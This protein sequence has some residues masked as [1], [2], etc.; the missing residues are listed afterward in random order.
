MTHRSEPR[1]GCPHCKGVGVVVV[2]HDPDLV[3]ECPCTQPEELRYRL[4]WRDDAT[5]FVAVFAG[6][7]ADVWETATLSRSETEHIRR[8]MPNGEQTDILL[9]NEA[10]EG[11]R[12]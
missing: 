11:T 2:T 6:L 9:V 5:G 1:P 4:R 10:G 3:D 12:V 8:Q 7:W